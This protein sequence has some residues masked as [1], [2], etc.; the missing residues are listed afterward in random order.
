MGFEE[1]PYHTKAFVDQGSEYITICSIPKSIGAQSERNQFLLKKTPYDTKTF[2]DQSNVHKTT[3]SVPKS[4]GAQSERNDFLQTFARSLPWILQPWRS[5]GQQR[6]TRL[7]CYA[8]HIA[9]RLL[10]NV[11]PRFPWL[12]LMDNLGRSLRRWTN[13]PVQTVRKSATCPRM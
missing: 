9:E 1:T 10:L 11:S 7:A 12:F 3:C 6:N 13:N 4:I 5:L 2:I 8:L